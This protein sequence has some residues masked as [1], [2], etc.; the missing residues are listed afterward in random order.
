MKIIQLIYCMPLMLCHSAIMAKVYDVSY[1]S[2]KNDIDFNTYIGPIADN[3]AA[4]PVVAGTHSKVSTQQRLFAYARIACESDKVYGTTS[5]CYVQRYRW[6]LWEDNPLVPYPYL[7]PS[8]LADTYGCNSNGIYSSLTGLYSDANGFYNVPQGDRNFTTPQT[9]IA[10]NINPAYAE[11]LH[12]I[13]DGKQVSITQNICRYV[14]NTPTQGIGKCINTPLYRDKVITNTLNY[15]KVGTLQLKTINQRN[16]IFIDSDGTP[17]L[18][19]GTP[20]CNEA[21]VSGAT[22]VICEVS[23]Y[24]FTTHSFPVNNPFS[25]SLRVS[26][27]QLNAKVAVNDVKIS[28]DKATWVGKDERI[29]LDSMLNKNRIYAFFSKNYFKA[30][31]EANL[32]GSDVD[33]LRFSFF[34]RDM[35]SSGYYEFSPSVRFD[36]KSRNYSVFI[37]AKNSINHSYAEGMVGR[38]QLNFPYT[39]VESGPVSASRLE[40]RLSQNSGIPFNGYCTFYQEGIAIPIPSSLVF[41]STTQGS[42]YQHP[43]RCD[44]TPV[45]IRALGIK[46]ARPVEHWIESDNSTGQTRYYDLSLNFNLRDPMALRTST[47]DQ[48]EG[49][50][51]QSGTLELRAIWN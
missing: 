2:I 14:A 15:K 12:Q 29:A 22:G 45:D 24:D 49:I 13:Q 38:D 10:A 46:D 1:I 36:L 3:I 21:T 11:A 33:V 47:G 37:Q 20:G 35:P 42:N 25:F 17:H 39:L 26:N 51:T 34:H 27:G 31:I 32:L 23:S 8:C 7:G 44:A 9:I 30:L 6:D 18:L 19:P 41:N 28:T 5:P 43:I 4:T 40:L 50:A 48:W 16:Q